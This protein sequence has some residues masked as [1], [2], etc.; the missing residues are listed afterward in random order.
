VSELPPQVEADC[1]GLML[2]RQVRRFDASKDHGISLKVLRTP[3]LFS[4]LE[5][6]AARK[7][8]KLGK[9]K[10]VTIKIIL[11]TSWRLRR[12]GSRSDCIC[13]I[14]FCEKPWQ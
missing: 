1:A 12:H 4:R 3:H 9:T 6:W 7:P 11:G 14:C 2:T 10:K 8:C 5:P 13:E